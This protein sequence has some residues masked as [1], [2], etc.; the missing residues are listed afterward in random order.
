M[1]RVVCFFLLFSFVYYILE[2]IMQSDFIS[3]C[4]RHIEINFIFLYGMRAMSMIKQSRINFVLF[5]FSSSLIIFLSLLKWLIGFDP[6]F[7]QIKREIERANVREK[8]LT[9]SHTHTHVIYLEKSQSIDI[10]LY[11]IQINLSKHEL[12]KKQHTAKT[13]KSLRNMSV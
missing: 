10:Y 8:A 9:H 2:C 4:C 1:T 12:K 7:N 5:D 13:T 3:S 11:K 6:F